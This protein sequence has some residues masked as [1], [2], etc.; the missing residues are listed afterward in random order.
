M[1]IGDFRDRPPSRA[2]SRREI[3]RALAGFGLALAAMP[4]GRRTA[5]AAEE[6]TF[7]TW[8]GYDVPEMYE[9]YTEKYGSVPSITLFGDDEEGL[10]K[11]RAGFTVDVSHPCYSGI[12]R[13]RDAG[14]TQPVDTS[15][16]KNWPDVLPTLQN[17]KGLA[18]EGKQWLIPIDWGNTSIIYRPDLVDID[19]ESWG[20]MW[21]E[22]Y[23]NRLAASA[24]T[25]DAAI[26]GALYM[27]AADPYNLTDAELEKL[28]EVLT[29]QR[30]L[31]QFYSS[32]PSTIEQS[33]ASG[34]IVAAVGWN[35]SYTQ[36]KKQGVPVKFM[37]PKEGIITWICG[38]VLMK[39]APNIDKAYDLI[40]AL[41]AP[42]T[43]VY[44]ITEF[45][46]GHSNAK[47]YELAGTEALEAAGIPGN[48]GEML[49]NATLSVD[50]KNKQAI[51]RMLVEVRS[52]F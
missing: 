49:R 14:V 36:L 50:M 9:A 24:A 45:G 13:W 19:E 31:V 20:L 3:N 28:R 1:T 6:A 11:I 21:D 10:Q 34:E 51:E 25:E 47:S 5:L 29:E 48:P 2:I 16:L 52:G 37:V 23:R 17:I 42:S 33:L 35:S 30:S 39:D 18:A 26:P 40:D 22:R 7:F 8:S 38:A 46:Y 32:D 41:I 44:M 27:G 43:G 15:R 4:M 12:D